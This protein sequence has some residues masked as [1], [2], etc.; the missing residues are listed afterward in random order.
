MQVA[1]VADG[2]DVQV[3]L[4]GDAPDRGVML[5][6]EAHGVA[7]MG[8]ARRTGAHAGH[9]LVVPGA[10]VPNRAGDAQGVE[11][12]DEL[13]DAGNLGGEGRVA[14][15]PARRVLV[16]TEQIDARGVHQQVLGHGALV[17]AREAGSLEMDTQKRGAIIGA[18]LDDALRLLHAPERLFGR[19]GEHRA[20][21]AGHA[22]AGEEPADGS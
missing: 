9:G 21:P 1:S 20:E 2:L 17:F 7:Q 4:D 11:F 3:A 14:H 15:V 8:R 6:E 12:G 19:I 22:L 18:A 10:A 13:L 16:L 5:M